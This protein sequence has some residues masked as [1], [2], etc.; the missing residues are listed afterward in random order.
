MVYDHGESV[1]DTG[2]PVPPRSGSQ[3]GVPLGLRSP[4][5]VCLRCPEGSPCCFLLDGGVSPVGV[6]GLGVVFG[7]CLLR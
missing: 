7:V 1:S 6:D 4:F 3:L 5:P 2:L